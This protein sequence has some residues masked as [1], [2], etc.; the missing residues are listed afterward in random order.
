MPRVMDTT[1]PLNGFIPRFSDTKIILRIVEKDVLSLLLSY[2]VQFFFP[3]FSKLV[4]KTEQTTMVI[5]LLKNGRE[6][7]KKNFFSLTRINEFVCF[8]TN[9]S[10]SIIIIIIIFFFFLVKYFK[11][12]LS[13]W[14]KKSTMIIIIL[15]IKF[16][17]L[18]NRVF[19]I[20][21]SKIY[22]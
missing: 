20:D 18:P 5:L 4:W 10:R 16:N 19:P 12:I 13:F 9:E 6:P 8:W 3:Y 14:K 11:F 15:I 2:R 1:W 7:E 21:M 17:D 22:I